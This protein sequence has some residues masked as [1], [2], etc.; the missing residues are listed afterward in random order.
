MIMLLKDLS[1]FASPLNDS[2]ANL[3]K[4]LSPNFHLNN[5]LG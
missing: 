2:Q 1:G 3:L 4:Q 5:W